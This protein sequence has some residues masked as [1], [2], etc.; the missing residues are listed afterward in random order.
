[1]FKKL[2]KS[3][4]GSGLMENIVSIS[5]TS[6]VLA[7]AASPMLMAFHGNTAARTYAGVVSDVQGIVDGIRNSH[8]NQILSKFDTAFLSITD[9]Q[10]TTESISNSESRA[11]YTIT[12][13][14]I[15]RSA[16]SVPDAIK[17]RVNVLHNIGT[18]G[19][20]T[21]SFETVVSQAG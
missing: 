17:L 21:Y 12:Y 5:I 16:T 13:T 1:M 14:A 6:I 11:T 2:F 8:Y 18:L 19:S 4:L 10:T 3:E 9:G 20:N 15:K 7:S